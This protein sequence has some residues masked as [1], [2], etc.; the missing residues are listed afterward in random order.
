MLETT[1]ETEKCTAHN[2]NRKSAL[3]VI[4]EGAHL[5]DALKLT[6]MT[7]FLPPLGESDTRPQNMED[8]HCA[9]VNEVCRYAACVTISA[10]DKDSSSDCSW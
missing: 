1:N 3:L 8:R 2:Y 10:L 6:S 4:L 5:Q 7:N 9:I